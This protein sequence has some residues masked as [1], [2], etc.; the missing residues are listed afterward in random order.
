MGIMVFSLIVRDRTVTVLY[1]LLVDRGFGAFDVD[2]GDDGDGDGID[3]SGTNNIPCMT[4]MFQSAYDPSIVMGVVYTAASA[5]TMGTPTLNVG[6]SKVVA[7]VDAEEEAGV[8]EDE[9]GEEGDFEGTECS[10]TAT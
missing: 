7:G 8:F 6:M 3:K 9:G 10:K 5:A 4:R 1:I 2:S